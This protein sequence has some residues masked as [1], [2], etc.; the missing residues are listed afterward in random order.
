MSELAS[1]S[2]LDNNNGRVEARAWLIPKIAEA[3]QKYPSYEISRIF[4]EFRLPFAPISQPDMLF[5]DPH[6]N[7]SQGLGEIVLANGEYKGKTVKTPLLP[8]ALVGHQFGCSPYR[9]SS[10][11]SWVTSAFEALKQ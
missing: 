11:G 3:M 2:E 9:C 1:Q 8:I 5:E 7:G 6:L 4:E 10:G